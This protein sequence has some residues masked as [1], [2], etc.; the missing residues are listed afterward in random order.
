M[1]EAL[2]VEPPKSG[3]PGWAHTA[4]GKLHEKPLYDVL[5]T[6]VIFGA[7]IF[8]TASIASAGMAV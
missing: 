2:L 4:W 8:Y 6:Y 5:Y 1:R 3:L 7:T